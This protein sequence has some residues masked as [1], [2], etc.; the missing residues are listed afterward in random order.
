MSDLHLTHL[1]HCQ[2]CGTACSGA[3]GLVNHYRNSPR[4]PTCPRCGTGF[5]DRSDLETH[6]FNSMNHQHCESCE[7]GFKEEEGLREHNRIQ[8]SRHSCNVCDKDFASADEL[9]AH[10]KTRGV[11]VLCEFC[12]AAF[13]NTGQMI[14]VGP[15]HP[16]INRCRLQ[17]ASITRTLTSPL[18]STTSTLRKKRHPSLLYLLYAQLRRLLLSASCPCQQRGHSIRC[19]LTATVATS[20]FRRLRLSCLICPSCPCPALQFSYRR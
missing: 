1:T 17:Y 14:D 15:V 6:Y 5:F 13:K 16:C 11:H 12:N 20:R 2:L 9:K 4:H 8:H 7:I 3:A 19:L 10:R 18:R